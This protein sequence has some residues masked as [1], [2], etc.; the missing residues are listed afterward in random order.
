MAQQLKKLAIRGIRSF[1]PETEET[2]EFYNPLTMIVG[3]NGCGKTTIIECLKY[4][5]TGS[6][7]PGVGKGASFVSDP[8][9]SDSSQVKANIKVRLEDGEC[10]PTVITRSFQV[11]KKPNKVEFKALDGTVRFIT[12]FRGVNK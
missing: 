3:A 10:M 11:T 12:D 6:M 5:S 2:I 4:I 9:I 1:D 8:S 7:P